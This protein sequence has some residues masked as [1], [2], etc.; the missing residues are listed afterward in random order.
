MAVRQASQ[1]GVRQ[2]FAEGGDRH[3]ALGHAAI[4]LRQLRN[5]VLEHAAKG[6]AGTAGPVE[7]GV[8]SQPGAAGLVLE[9]GP[10]RAVQQGVGDPEVHPRAAVRALHDEAGVAVE[11]RARAAGE[12][13][14]RRRPACGG[15][16]RHP[17]RAAQHQAER[18]PRHGGAVGPRLHAV[19]VGVA[20]EV[21]VRAERPPREARE[22]RPGGLREPGGIAQ[23]VGVGGLALAQAGGDRGVRAEL[24]R[25]V[26][27]EQVEAAQRRRVHRDHV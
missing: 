12:D 21:E 1:H 19:A 2:E 7:R 6:G 27:V 8:E 15:G 25:V 9:Q 23:P 5:Q 14:R 4:R 16:R 22:Q 10:Q 3:W 24:G 13:D 11:D 26:D 20:G 18:H 17:G